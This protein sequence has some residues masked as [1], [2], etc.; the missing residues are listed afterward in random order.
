MMLGTHPRY[1]HPDRG[2]SASFPG[3]HPKN[4]HPDRSEPALSARVVEGSLLDLLSGLR[5]ARRRSL[6]IFAALL[7]S[8]L[9]TA[10]SFSLTTRELR[11]E[12]FHSDVLVMPDGS[13]DVTEIIQAHFLSPHTASTIPYS[14][15]S[16]A[17]A[18]AM[19][20]LSNSTPAASVTI[21][22]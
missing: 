6:A 4:C 19:A 3:T 10:P 5:R 12:N 1:C 18:T 8:V 21:A 9:F 15:T 2:Q 22:S 13:V 14:S 11:I 7:T 20:S 17:S 16:S